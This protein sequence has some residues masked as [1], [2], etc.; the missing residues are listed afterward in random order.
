ML[1]PLFKID[2]LIT[3]CNDVHNND[4]N[5]NIIKFSSPMRFQRSF[6]IM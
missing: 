5:D 2:Y 3:L 6:N 4:N 1:D